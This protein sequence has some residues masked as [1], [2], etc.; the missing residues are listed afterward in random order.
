MSINSVGVPQMQ[1]M[2]QFE[3]LCVTV[4]QYRTDVIQ[5]P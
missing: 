1:K 3:N 2:I 4:A 5:L